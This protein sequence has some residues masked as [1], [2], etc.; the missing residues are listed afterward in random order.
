MVGD[1]ASLE[2]LRRLSSLAASL[3]PAVG[4]GPGDLQ[5]FRDLIMKRPDD[6]RRKLLGANVQ[7]RRALGAEQRQALEILNVTPDLLSPLNE[8][9]YEPSHSRLVSRF[10]SEKHEPTLGPK[11]LRAFLRLVG[12]APGETDALNAE[13]DCELWVSTGRID[14]SVSLQKHLIFVEMKVDAEEGEEQLA[15]YNAA[16]T[17]SRGTRESLLVYLTRADAEKPTTKADHVHVTLSDLLRI[18]IPF[19]GPGDGSAQYLARYLKS[20]A[21][22]EGYASAGSFDDWS[23]TQ[24]ASAIELVASL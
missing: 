11:L 23:M 13:V 17:A 6:L 22:V 21:L 1:T 8:L 19:A 20:I 3:G 10:L 2:Y 9:R 5:L 7:R 4:P 12:L 15:R 14:I 18:W 24:Q 16:L